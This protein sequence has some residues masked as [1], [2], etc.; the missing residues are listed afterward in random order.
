[1]ME[2]LNVDINYK[3][4]MADG[5]ERRHPSRYKGTPFLHTLIF[6]IMSLCLKCQYFEIMSIY[7]VFTE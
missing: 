2:V 6:L 3:G 5:S 7:M 1:M 4:V